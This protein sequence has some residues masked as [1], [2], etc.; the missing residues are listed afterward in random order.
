LAAFEV[1]VLVTSKVFGKKR[2]FLGIC[3]N[4]PLKKNGSKGGLEGIL[5]SYPRFVFSTTAQLLESSRS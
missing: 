4:V 3:P 2:I 1:L 5:F